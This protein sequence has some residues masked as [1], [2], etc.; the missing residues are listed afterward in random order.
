MDQKYQPRG[1]PL[2]LGGLKDI[3]RCGR[4]ESWEDFRD[5]LCVHVFD[6][7]FREDI[8]KVGGNRQVASFKKL[9]GGETRPP[10]INFATSHRTT[11]NEQA[12]GVSMIGTART[13]LLNRSAEF[14]HRQ[15]NDVLHAVTEI[16][17]QGCQTISEVFQS[18]R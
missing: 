10:A 7:D 11:S 18:G 9:F 2:P 6:Q 15:D 13:V 4:F 8:P 5:I 1:N 16:P 12:T 3:Q 14:S 17:I